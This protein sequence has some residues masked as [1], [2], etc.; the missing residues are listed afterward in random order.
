MT[1]VFTIVLSF[2][3]VLNT[4]A[5]ETS[6]DVSITAS[7]S[8]ASMEEAQQS[9]LRSATEQAFGAFIS[10]KTEI[11]NDQLVADQISSVS[12]GNIKSFDI[13]NQ[14]VLPD[15]RWGCTLKAIVSVDKLTS[16]VQAKGIA[17]EIK[18]GLFALNIKQQLLNEQGEINAVTEM[19][20][21]LHENLQRSFDYAISSG[22]PQ[23]VDAGK[24]W[25]IPLSVKA[26][27]NKNMD[28]CA[29]YLMKTLGGISQ[30][31]T[32]AESYMSLSKP[33]YIVEIKRNN[34]SIKYY[35]RKSIS[36]DA[37][38]SLS[39]NWD[40]YTKLFS[41]KTGMQEL[42]GNKIEYL[43]ENRNSF[44]FIG[45]AQPLINGGKQVAINFP[46]S[47]QIAKEYSW[48]IVKT[49]EEIEQMTD[50]SVRPI[51]VYSKFSN[52]GFVVHEK[53]GHGLVL[54]LIDIGEESIWNDAKTACD[55]LV[56]NG[57][58]DWRLPTKDELEL[59]INSAF[60]LGIRFSKKLPVDY[61]SSSPCTDSDCGSCPPKN[62]QWVMGARGSNIGSPFCN[63]N[64]GWR[65]KVLA[66]RTY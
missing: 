65:C 50:I 23:S 7:G 39:T 9:A 4:S 61:W 42:S 35:L 14:A 21:L 40:F 44:K 45:T 19:V 8:G 29:D 12:S 59:V 36:F 2:I 43:G 25:S 56:L 58:F 27:Y 17:I 1:K 20:G 32:E 64:E 10:S 6:K 60:K 48:D 33:V 16:F 53:D 26:T 5:Q 66:V 49:L 52:G 55:E 63:K 51:G 47:G 31:K 18:G 41:V 38:T 54:S 30:S 11:F 57:Y 37:I 3:L 15:G 34:Q 28:F 22:E 13:L 24:K 62:G 46:S